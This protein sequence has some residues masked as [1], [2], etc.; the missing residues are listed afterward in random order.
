[1][2]TYLLLPNIK[3]N[4]QEKS[5]SNWIA[6]DSINFTI[7]RHISTLPGQVYDRELSHP[8]ISEMVITKT[9]DNSSV[10]LFQSAC[11]A[12]AISSAT[13]DLCQTNHSG[14][15]YAKITLENIIITHYALI[16][17]ATPQQ[18][19]I[20]SMHINFDHIE[21]RYTPYGKDNQA[22]SPITAGYDLKQAKTI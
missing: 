6:I 1:M 3:G 16:S 8:N 15:A 14:N 10:L 2:S 19:P 21:F 4:V 12:K 20:E 9:I 17:D 13:I 7:N 5:H 18:R 22:L 11:T